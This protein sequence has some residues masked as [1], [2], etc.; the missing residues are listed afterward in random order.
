MTKREFLIL[1]QILKSYYLDWSFDL[2]NR[3]LVETWFQYLQD[4]GSERLKRV[5]NFYISKHDAGPNSPRDLMRAHFELELKEK[6][7][8]TEEQI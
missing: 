1:L 5:V 7:N 6:I 8:D 3:I 4:L 2:T